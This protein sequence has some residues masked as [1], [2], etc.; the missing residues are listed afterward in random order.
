MSGEFCLR[1]Q[2]QVFNFLVLKGCFY[3]WNVSRLHNQHNQVP[4]DFPVCSQ[5]HK[6][7]FSLLQLL[8]RYEIRKAVAAPRQQGQ[9]RSPQ[10]HR[11]S[12]VRLASRVGG[13]R[14]GAHCPKGRRRSVK[15]LK[16][17]LLPAFSFTTGLR[18][19]GM[20]EFTRTWSLVD[21]A[22]TTTTPKHQPQ[23]AGGP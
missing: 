20:E 17:Q 10:E 11:E 15:N 23:S 16:R 3:Q 14:F 9:A 8:P 2:K 22:T 7:P 13:R 5:P 18:A 4:R 19:R 6:R 21:S 12:A 1:N